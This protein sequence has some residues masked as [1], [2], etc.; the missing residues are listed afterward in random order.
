MRR[1]FYPLIFLIALAGIILGGSLEATFFSPVEHDWNAQA[2]A[3][4]DKVACEKAHDKCEERA[5]WERTYC[6]PV[7]AFTLFLTIFTG[8]LAVSTIGLWFATQ[9]ILRDAGVTSRK[10]LRAYVGVESV[11]ITDAHSAG[12]KI[13]IMFRNYGQTPAYDPYANIECD[14]F[15]EALNKGFVVG[16]KPDKS[17]PINP[18]SAYGQQLFLTKLIPDQITALRRGESELC[19]WG[20]MTYVDCFGDKREAGLRVVMTGPI[21]ANTIIVLDDG[22]EAT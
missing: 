4:G 13:I 12:I 3:Q 16:T 14:L 17:Y 2:C 18:T 9:S 19:V 15:S 1:F 10:E 22:N 21:N 7:A 11:T 8:I 6:E 20:K 5:F